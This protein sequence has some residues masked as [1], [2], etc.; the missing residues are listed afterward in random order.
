MNNFWAGE[1]LRKKHIDII[2]INMGNLCNLACNHCHIGA[3]PAGSDNM[4]R[5]T[6]EKIA[7]K[8]KN[9]G[10]RK[11]EFTGGEPVLNTNL[12]YF[13]EELSGIKDI[14][15]RTNLLPMGM[16][17]YKDLISLFKKYKIALVGSLPSPFQKATDSQRGRGVFEKSIRILKQLNREGFGS[18]GFKLDL[19][20]NPAGDYLPPDNVQLERDYRSMLQDS[21]G[22]LFN[23][24][25]PIVNIPIKRFRKYLEEQSAL[26]Q[27]EKELRDRYNPA[28]LDRIMCRSLLSVDYN[29]YVYDCDFNLAAGTRIKKYKSTRLWE[30]DLDDFKPEIL[31][32]GYCYAC[33]VNDGSSCHGSLINKEDDMMDVKNIVKTYYGEKLTT[34]HDLQTNACCTTDSVPEYVKESLRYVNDEIKMKYYGCGSPIPHALDGLKALDVGCGTGRDVY[35]L[36]SL[37]GENGFAWGIDMTENQ[38]AVANKYVADQMDI[39][40]Y[41]KSN[42]KFIHDYIE[43]LKS[44]FDKEALDLIISNCVINLAEDKAVVLKQIYNILKFGGEFYFSDVYADRR[45]PGQIARQ[46]VLYGECLGGA[47]YYKDFERIAKKVGFTDPRVISSQAITIHNPEIEKLVENINFCSIT[48]RLWK[49]EGFEDAC[50]DYGHIAVYRGGIPFAPFKYELDREHVFYKN[51]PER[52]CG[53]TA[54]MLQDTRYGKYFEIIG[55]FSEHFGAFEDCARQSGEKDETSNGLQGCC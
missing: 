29:G 50:E 2:Q 40:G 55:D 12:V 18:N 33:T 5:A 1:T 20:Y 45:V 9:V 25:I 10:V 3:S 43:N 6:A 23:N 28:N 21:Y 26:A 4:N 47:L 42:V 22:I 19:V 35:I 27:Y 24:F 30:I 17:E 31:F 46:E 41:S 48:Y 54:K 37:T 36:S 38:L 32:A 52:V 16:P 8:L 11:V 7:D 13:I 44:H 49:I 53:N 51:K 14:V 34:S 15:V 39:F